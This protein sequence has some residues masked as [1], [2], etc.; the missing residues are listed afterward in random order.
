MGDNGKEECV[1]TDCGYPPSVQSA[2]R[3]VSVQDVGL[4]IGSIMTYT[5]TD[6]QSLPV[7]EQKCLLSGKWSQ[8]V[9]YSKITSCTQL[10]DCN[11][12][13]SDGEYWFYHSDT[14]DQVVKIYCHGM[15]TASPKEFVSLPNPS[16]SQ[17]FIDG[18]DTL[19]KQTEKIAGTIRRRCGVLTFDKIALKNYGSLQVD[20]ADWTFASTTCDYYYLM[21]LGDCS[22]K[23][24]CTLNT[25]LDQAYIDTHGTS[26][27]IPVSKLWKTTKGTK[28]AVFTYQRSDD[29]KAI[30][31]TLKAGCGGY[32]H[33]G[34]GL[35]L[36]FDPLNGLESDE[37]TFP[38]C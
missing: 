35:N 12:A 10:Q 30:N 36:E 3:D 21:A 5:C 2:T 26:F 19:C 13:Y 23:A 18:D 32:A 33:A 14:P 25:S 17:Q 15:T 6:K 4:Q 24:D 16:I 29:N 38:V 34:K 9:C 22:S 8:F 20:D 1:L 28:N 11:A 27:I 37:A 7:G 31:I